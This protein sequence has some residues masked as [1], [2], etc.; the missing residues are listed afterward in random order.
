MRQKMNNTLKSS[1]TIV[2]DDEQ[3]ITFN[4]FDIS[5]ITKK[6]YKH[7]TSTGERFLIVGVCYNRKAS[8]TVPMRESDYNELIVNFKNFIE[9]MKEHPENYQLRAI[10]AVMADQISDI[11]KNSVTEHIEAKDN[12]EEKMLTLQ[13]EFG[14][15]LLAYSEKATQRMEKSQEDLDNRLKD[16]ESLFQKL[17][18]V[19]D[20]VD[21]FL[22]AESEMEK[23]HSPNS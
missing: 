18:K 19:T 22:I 10:N 6:G 3:E 7:Y 15:Q 12:I 11:I 20:L 14:K 2:V 5:N 21:D 8:S 16:V 4:F 23:K 1:M 17:S 9:E 13:E